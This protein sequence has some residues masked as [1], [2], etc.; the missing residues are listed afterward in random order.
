MISIGKP[1]FHKFYYLSLSITTGCLALLYFFSSNYFAL[2]AVII[3]LGLWSTVSYHTLRKERLLH[4]GHIRAMRVMLQQ[5][6]PLSQTVDYSRDSLIVLDSQY[7]ILDISPYASQILGTHQTSLLGN[8]ID[9]YLQIPNI[10]SPSRENHKGELPWKKAT[11]EIIHLQYCIRPLL[12]QGSPSGLLIILYDISEEKRRYEAYLQAAKFSVVGQVAAGLAHELRNPLTTI[13]G[14]MQLIGAEH[15]PPQFR[16]YHQLI[17][18]EI[19]TTDTLLSNFLLLTNPT[20]PQLQLLNPEKLV[21]SAVQILLPSSLMN[22]VTLNVT[23]NSPVSAILGDEE[24]LLRAL[25]AVIQNSIDASPRNGQILIFLGDRQEHFEIKVIDH[26]T[27]IPNDIRKN[28]FDP[29]F[30]TRN[31]G[32]GLGLTIAQRILLAHHGELVIDSDTTPGTTVLL[33]IPINKSN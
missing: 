14:F 15:F 9:N 12:D 18:D 3:I 20:A 2:I 4:Q 27:G 33:R 7:N 30:T 1:G 32:T 19:Q 8:P 21:N 25:L 11:G 24:Q 17:L 22:E 5:D 26:G 10:K 31:E 13:K 16:P 28:I 29:F 23:V 6:P